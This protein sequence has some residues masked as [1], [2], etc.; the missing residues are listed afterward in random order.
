MIFIDNSGEIVFSKGFDLSDD[1]EILV[2]KSLFDL[3]ERRDKLS[4]HTDIQGATA[5]VLTLP[6]YIIMVSSRPKLTTSEQGPIRG[7]LIFVRN[8]RRQRD[9]DIVGHHPLPLE[10]MTVDDPVLHPI[11]PRHSRTP[12]DRAETPVFSPA[13]ISPVTR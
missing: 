7:T 4:L 13:R 3:I 8:H 2:P 6:E 1:R 5:G 11:S 10:S 9:P 12:Q